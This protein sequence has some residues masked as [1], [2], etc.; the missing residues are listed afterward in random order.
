[1]DETKVED[2]EIA[3]AILKYVGENGGRIPTCEELGKIV[4]LSGAAIR[5]REPWI[6][7]T[8]IVATR[9]F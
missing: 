3:A 1:M 7:R 5:K 2:K 9:I 8:A 4:G 6:N